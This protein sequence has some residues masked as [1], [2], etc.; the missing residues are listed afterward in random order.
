M[1]KGEYIFVYGTLRQGERAD[2]ASGFYSYG[3]AFIDKDRI[4]GRLYHL[5]AF[6][7]VKS[8]IEDKAF[9]GKKSSVTGEV[10][11]ILDTSIVAILDAYEGYRPDSPSSGLYDRHQVLT[12]EGRQVWV[13][14][15]NHPVIE[16]QRISGGDWCKNR[17]TVNI[18][19]LRA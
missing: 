10:F 15:Y 1:K 4:N 2:L 9:D 11:R 18:R 17:D 14:T 8:I 16:D 13:Y 5:G 6:P 3:I 19:R 12:E 7:G